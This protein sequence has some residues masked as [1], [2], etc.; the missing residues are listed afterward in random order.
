MF[1][2]DLDSGQG[3]ANVVDKNGTSRLSNIRVE[4]QEDLCVCTCTSA[5]LCASSLFYFPFAPLKL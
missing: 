1:W 2:K 5:V 3:E 4:M